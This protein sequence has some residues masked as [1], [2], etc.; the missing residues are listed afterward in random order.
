M[1]DDHILGQYN[2][3]MIVL[4]KK[5]E[6]LCAFDNFG[7][8]NCIMKVKSL[9][10]MLLL[11]QRCIKV[12]SRDVLYIFFRNY[13]KCCKEMSRGLCASMYIRRYVLPSIHV[14]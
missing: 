5:C 7:A 2:H 3:E 1:H 13:S 4:L 9:T 12:N 14:L 11:C 6:G 8:S 10:K